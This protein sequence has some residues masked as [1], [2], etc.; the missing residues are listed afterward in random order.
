V[1][2][3]LWLRSENFVVCLETRYGEEK[4]SKQLIILTLEF[5]LFYF[6]GEAD[7]HGHCA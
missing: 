2:Y 7:T 6:A 1:I 3:I 5:K 4:F